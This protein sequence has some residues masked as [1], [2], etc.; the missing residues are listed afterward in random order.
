MDLIGSWYPRLVPTCPQR[1]GEKEK[2]KRKEKEKETEK[3]KS[4]ERNG[5]EWRGEEKRRD[6]CTSEERRSRT[7]EDKIRI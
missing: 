6:Y 5:E 3:E 1:R 2:E 7:R 4:G